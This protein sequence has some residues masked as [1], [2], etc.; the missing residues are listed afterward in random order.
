MDVLPTKPP[1]RGS[2]RGC[3]WGIAMSLARFALYYEYYD[4]TRPQITIGVLAR[5]CAQF[6]RSLASTTIIMLGRISLHAIYAHTRLALVKAI[7]H[8]VVF[9]SGELVEVRYSNIQ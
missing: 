5:D 9:V 8:I 6:Q 1:E 4:S 7:I 2:T 3:H